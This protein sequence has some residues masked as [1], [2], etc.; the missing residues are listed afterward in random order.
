M[1]TYLI[2]LSCSLL[3]TACVT[4]KNDDF[5]DALALN[6]SSQML[7][8]TDWVIISGHSFNDNDIKTN[9]DSLLPNNGARAIVTFNNTGQISIRGGC[10][11]LSGFWSLNDN[12]L[13]V[14]SLASTKMACEASLMDLDQAVQTLFSNK[15]ITA[16]VP[17]GLDN[18]LIRM[19]T[20]DNI[21]YVMQSIN[22]IEKNNKSYAGK[23]F[24]DEVFQ[25]Y[26]W[27]LTSA[28]DHENNILLTNT[29]LQITTFSQEGQ[30]MIVKSNC[31]KAIFNMNLVKNNLSIG[32]IISGA[33]TCSKIDN[34]LTNKH[35]YIKG[36]M[37][38]KNPEIKFIG[39][40]G[41]II[42]L[43]GSKKKN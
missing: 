2:F 40:N 35:F 37:I 14:S 9:L 5:L 16:R 30:N 33:D 24:S 27:K 19:Q 29:P 17:N 43:K 20:N 3:F 39:S 26:E 25:E 1:K 18:S 11:Q 32:N 38:G 42:S 10:N 23:Y 28:L 31:G 36:E 6:P 41:D 12:V 4:Q 8:S 21:Y 7:T 22:N 34:A 13:K 15:T